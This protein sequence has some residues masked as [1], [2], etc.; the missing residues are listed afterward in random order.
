MLVE[1]LAQ[2]E[3]TREL[4]TNVTTEYNFRLDVLIT[5]EKTIFKIIESS[6]L[7]KKVFCKK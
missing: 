4:A 3:K 7:F 2:I 1:I 5:Q 6:C